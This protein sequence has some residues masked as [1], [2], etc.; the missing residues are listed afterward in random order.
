MILIK[1]EV[2][3]NSPCRIAYVD[4]KKTTGTDKAVTLTPNCVKLTVHQL[5]SPIRI[6][7]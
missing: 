1:A 4:T 6:I 7:I 5:K 2:P 3:A